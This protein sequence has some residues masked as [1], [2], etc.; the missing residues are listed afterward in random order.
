MIFFEEIKEMN[1]ERIIR[2]CG[3]NYAKFISLPKDFQVSLLTKYFEDYQN[4]LDKNTEIKEKIKV[5][6]KRNK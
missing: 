1:R 2:A 6:L 3:F 5:L 4:N